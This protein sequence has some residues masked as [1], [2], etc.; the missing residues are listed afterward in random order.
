MKYKII[1]T[2]VTTINCINKVDSLD[3]EQV[4]D[5]QA[6]LNFLEDI[7]DDAMFV[8]KQEKGKRD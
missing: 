7:L 1:D 4:A 5:L 6:N 8:L 2:V 3:D